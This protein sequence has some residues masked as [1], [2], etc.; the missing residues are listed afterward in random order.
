MLRRK[1][2]TTAQRRAFYE[3]KRGDN[4]YPICNLC[5][6]PIRPGQDWEESHEGAPHA[7]G[8]ART[9]IAHKRC[10]RLHGAKVVTP[11]V[12]KAKRQFDR[13]HDIWVSRNPLPG[14]KDDPRKRTLD[15][16]VVD[17][18]TGEPWRPGKRE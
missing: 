9:G 15:G 8:G 2:M 17:R 4:A 12:A 16:R 7:L 1:R 14:H 13:H 18:V 10:N 5:S 6:L 11:M 3:D